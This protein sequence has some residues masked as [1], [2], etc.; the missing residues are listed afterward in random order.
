[1]ER[2]VLATK[3]TIMLDE[4]IPY[5][6]IDDVVDAIGKGYK[7]VE[8][9]KGDN[10]ITMFSEKDVSDTDIDV[11]G[12]ERWIYKIVCTPVLAKAKPNVDFSEFVCAKDMVGKKP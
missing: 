10:I 12:M 5:R 7:D 11:Y 1:M 9:H 2:M 4:S 3:I 6:R 8:F